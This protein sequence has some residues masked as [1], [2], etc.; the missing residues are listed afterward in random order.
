[1]FNKIQLNAAQNF[2]IAQYRKNNRRVLNAFFSKLFRFS[3]RRDSNRHVD[4]QI[5]IRAMYLE[6]QRKLTLV[7]EVSSGANASLA[8]G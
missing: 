4:R 6:A 8:E 5:L 2:H 7:I 3:L 1:M